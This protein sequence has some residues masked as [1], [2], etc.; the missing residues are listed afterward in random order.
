MS[1]PSPDRPVR[2]RFAP[3]PTGYLHIGNLRSALF[4]YLYARHVGGRFILR[5]EDTDRER[6]VPEALDYINENLRWMGMDPDEG[7]DNPDPKYGPYIQSERLEQFQRYANQ[8][9]EEG[10]AYRD[11]TSAERL[12]ELRSAAQAAKQP[13]R[14]TKAMAQ[15][16]PTGADDPYVIRFRIQPGK[17]VVWQDAV[18]GEQ[19]W[20]RAVLDDFVALK[21]DGFPTYNFAVVI[22]DHLMEITHV[23]RGSEFLSTAPKNL[24]IYEALGWQPPVYAHLPQVLGP[25]KA[26]LSK[27]HGAKSALEYRDAG[28]LPEAILNFLATLG[29]NDGTPQELYT[30]EELIKAFALDRIQSSPAVF[31]AARLDW[32]N[33]HYIREL[34]LVELSKR[35][36]GFWPAAAKDAPT[37]YRHQVLGLVHERLK[38]LAELPELT[39]FFFADPQVGRQQL[40]QQLEDSAGLLRTVHDTL[41]D[42][43]FTEADLEQRLRSLVEEKGLKA[44]KL[45]GLIRLAI[46]GKTAAPGLFETLHV[47]GKEV[48]M[49]RLAAARS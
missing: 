48:A 41:A 21:S 17:D 44:G 1:H 4:S 19:R 3:S 49:R 16:E 47:L 18:W 9:V 27:R 33:G 26:K 6:F 13:F 32:M 23:F 31:D 15:L 2:V 28:Y 22:D 40:E 42:S 8:L 34:S 30:R 5:I 12:T 35:A 24:L 29:F 37:D 10:K 25:D 46:T 11:Y 38:F 39:E 36:E 14:F 45:F 7:P 43:D 20:E